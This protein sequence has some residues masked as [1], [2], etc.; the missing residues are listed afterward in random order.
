MIERAPVLFLA[1]KGDGHILSVNEDLCRALGYSH[2]ELLDKHV[3]TI[4]TIATRIFFQTHLF[5]M[6]SM[7]GFANE[8]YLTL[9]SQSGDELPVLVNVSRE[10]EKDNMV[11]FF[12]GMIVRNRK[13]FEDELVA[14]R[15]AAEKA[16][17]EN[18]SLQQA[19][20]EL[21]KQTR[22]LDEQIAIVTTQNEELRE[23]SRVVTHDMQEP[24]RK[25][26]IFTD[27]I[28]EAKA[29]DPR[30]TAKL[31]RVLEDLRSIMRSLQQY[32][33]LVE[34]QRHPVMI[35][36]NGAVQKAVANLKIEYPEV[37]VRVISEELPTITADKEQM[38]F[39][40]YEVLLNALKFRSNPTV[41]NISI[42]A[43][44]VMQNEYR[45]LADKYNYVA[46]HK[47]EITDDGNGFD[48]KYLH[49][50]FR[51]FEGFHEQSGRGVGLALCRKIVDSH[52]GKISI[53]GGGKQGTT[54]KILLPAG[55]PR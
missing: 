4:F 28:S 22:L 18:I 46:F 5:P 27:M 17:N 9:R 30:L 37:E 29:Y 41:V 26:S 50:A 35:D 45:A 2:D 15:K 23:F 48:E 39:L 3:E 20:Q 12:G 55:R 24:L 8:I 34:T 52:G 21:E 44:S 36:L 13:K 7:Q 40:I 19:K 33:W 42:Q 47:L 32:I 31:S 6:V 43:Y 49:K 25:I 16:L 38:Q 54:L 53:E 11:L 51:L 10:M 1:C 14:A